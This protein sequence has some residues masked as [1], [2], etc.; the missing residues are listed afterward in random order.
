[1]DAALE[2]MLNLL[3]ES[4]RAG[5]AVLDALAAEVKPEELRELLLD[6][7]AEEH[8]NALALERLIREGGG[9]PSAATGPFAAK[10]AA[11]ANTRGRLAL[12]IRGQEWVARKIEETLALAP[13]SGPI[14]ECL[15]KMAN[16]HR[17]E[18]EWGRAEL[19]RLMGVVE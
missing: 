7:R 1:M 11:V 9:A 13:A 16:R 3:L 6:A 5:V 2:R 15:Q 19:I 17:H 4:E 12:L 18:I 8:R 14:R 10:V